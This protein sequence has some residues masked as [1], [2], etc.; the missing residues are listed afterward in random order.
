MV[1]APIRDTVWE[2]ELGE[3][4]NV[5]PNIKTKN[6]TALIII[7]VKANLIQNE[8][9]LKGAK[10]ESHHTGSVVNLIVLNLNG[11]ELNRIRSAASRM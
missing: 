3:R 1:K 2:K 9:N 5:V 8:S 7:D 10:I 11:A 4:I 6:V